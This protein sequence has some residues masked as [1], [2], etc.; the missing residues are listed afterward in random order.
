MFYYVYRITCTHPHS[1]EKY[2]YGVRGTNKT[3]DQDFYWSSSKYVK[4]AI[5]TY[6]IVFFKKKILKTFADRQSAIAHEIFLHEKFNVDKHPLF[7]NRGKQTAWGFNCT[8][9]VLKGKTYEEILGEEKAKQLKKQRSEC[10]KK[11]AN[12]KGTNNPMYGKKHTPES[13]KKHSLKVSGDKHPQYGYFW[14]TNGVENRKINPLTDIIPVGWWKGRKTI[15]AE[16]RGNN[17]PQHGFVWITDGSSNRKINPL[18]DTIP[19]GWQRGRTKTS[20][21]TSATD[22]LA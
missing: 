14:V 16:V 19:M 9:A 2:Y 21:Q 4:D 12:N 17:H 6:G 13:K 8:G 7:F 5:G 18:T 22:L 20:I 11:I 3:P 10:Q 1:I 15:W